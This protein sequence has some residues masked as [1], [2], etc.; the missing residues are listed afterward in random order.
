LCKLKAFTE[1]I[2]NKKIES[3][4]NQYILD[5][6]KEKLVKLQKSKQIIKLF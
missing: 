3:E 4:E 5:L 1:D 2:E 6:T